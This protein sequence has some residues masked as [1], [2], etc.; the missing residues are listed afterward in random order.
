MRNQEFHKGV[1]GLKSLGTPV[2]EPQQNVLL[3]ISHSSRTSNGGHVRLLMNTG[4][5][6]K[7]RTMTQTTIRNF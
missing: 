2:L 4:S 5:I 1:D 3:N 6:Q 7:Q